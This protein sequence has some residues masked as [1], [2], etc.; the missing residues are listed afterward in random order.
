[1][2]PNDKGRLD[3]A[4]L[5]AIAEDNLNMAQLHKTIWTWL[6]I[7]KILKN[8]AKYDLKNGWWIQ[9]LD[10]GTDFNSLPDGSILDRSNWKH[11]Q[12]IK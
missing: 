11:L 4:E 8:Q 1:M 7:Q 5:K 9:T 2:V 12:T 3:L 10:N 6:K